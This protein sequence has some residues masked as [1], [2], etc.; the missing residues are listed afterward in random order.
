[1]APD[2]RRSSVLCCLSVRRSLGGCRGHE[3]GGRL[4]LGLAGRLPQPRGG[5]GRQRGGLY[6]PSRVALLATHWCVLPACLAGWWWCYDEQVPLEQAV[7]LA[8]RVASVSVQRPG[9]QSSYPSAD[10]LPPELR[11]PAAHEAKES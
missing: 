7:R 2:G 8:C 1:M 6:S 10:A 4:L 3:W 11:L 9:T 5:W